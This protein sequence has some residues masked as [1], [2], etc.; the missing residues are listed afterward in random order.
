MNRALLDMLDV[1]L[2]CIKHSCAFLCMVDVSGLARLLNA[3]HHAMQCVNGVHGV[4]EWV[5]NMFSTCWTDSGHMIHIPYI[6]IYH[7]SS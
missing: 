6:N 1:V 5:T 2:R 4:G 7:T 3:T